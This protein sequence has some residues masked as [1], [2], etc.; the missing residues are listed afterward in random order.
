MAVV[1]E[2]IASNGAHITVL[3]DAYAGVSDEEMAERWKRVE[4]IGRRMAINN[5]IRRRKREAEA[6]AAAKSE[7]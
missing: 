4:E 7:T 5:E 3:D 6:Q 2:F 1:K